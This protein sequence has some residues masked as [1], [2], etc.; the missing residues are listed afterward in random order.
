MFRVNGLG[1]ST[2]GDIRNGLVALFLDI[3]M[4]LNCGSVDSILILIR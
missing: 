4:K 3:T 2:N 1:I